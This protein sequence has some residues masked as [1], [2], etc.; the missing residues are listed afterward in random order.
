MQLSSILHSK[1][2]FIISPQQHF[3]RVH[4][5]TNFVLPNLGQHK[6]GSVL[7]FPPP[8]RSSVHANPDKAVCTESTKAG[9]NSAPAQARCIDCFIFSLALYFSVYLW[10][11]NT[12]RR[13]KKAKKLQERV[14]KPVF[15]CSCPAAFVVVFLHLKSRWE[16]G[17][18]WNTHTE[19]W[20]LTRK[21]ITEWCGTE[22]H[23]KMDGMGLLEP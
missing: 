17:L 5:Y 10:R 23:L 15:F 16:C 21:L 2:L 14:A 4:Q 1:L 3:Q 8:R 18:C 19:T 13:R 20:T 6:L 12:N 9:P 11:W 7:I 22:K